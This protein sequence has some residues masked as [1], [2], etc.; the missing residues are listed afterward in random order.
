MTTKSKKA[1]VKKVAVKRVPKKQI[2]T[3]ETPVKRGPGR[4]RKVVEETLI[5]KPVI[6]TSTNNNIRIIYFSIPG[7]L[8]GSKNYVYIYD[9]PTGSCQLFSAAYFQ[10]LKWLE[11]QAK[12]VHKT[13]PF[14][15]DYRPVITAMRRSVYS[16][17]L[18]FIDIKSTL[19]YFVREVFNKGEI[20]SETPYTSTNGSHMVLYTINV[21]GFVE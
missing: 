16:K 21:R 3:A 2:I 7:D 12:L 14:K 17:N 18:L 20:I 10:N 5:I 4:P 1:P 19:T 13:K 8:S 9:A 6:T 15:I 11:Y